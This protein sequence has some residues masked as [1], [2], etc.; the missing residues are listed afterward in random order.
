MTAKKFVDS[1]SIGLVFILAHI[2]MYTQASVLFPNNALEWQ[3]RI[4]VYIGI[5]ALVFG[6]SSTKTERELFVGHF[7]RRL[8]VFILFSVGT[9]TLLFLFGK[10]IEW[11]GLSAVSG[12]LA[13][14]GLGVILFHAFI[15]AVDEELIFRG[16]LND[17]LGRKTLGIW[18]RAIIISIVFAFFHYALAGSEPLVLF[19]YIPIGLAYFFIKEKYGIMASIG[20]HWAYNIFILGFIR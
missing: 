12:K 15:V 1:I 8:P 19:T 11:N 5:T 4:G 17:I 7:F 14:I 3:I 9:L 18:T 2:W 6:V 10:T 20:T 16:W 13:D